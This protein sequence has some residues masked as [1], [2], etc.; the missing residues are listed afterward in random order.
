MDDYADR[1][2][3]ASKELGKPVALCGWSIG[4]LVAL[5]AAEAMDGAALVLIEPSP[6]GEIQGFSPHAP[7]EEGPF[8]PEVVYGTF[9]RGIPSRPESN[10]ARGERKRG[11]S[12]PRVTCPTLVISGDEFVAERGVPVAALYGAEHAHFRGLDHW[13][14][15][16]S[17]EVR[18]RIATFLQR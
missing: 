10:R 17:A 13:D 11:I 1:V 14:L 7:L 3:A 2:V 18:G 5:M 9:P 8:D 15:V 4:G 16:R 6:P 12:V